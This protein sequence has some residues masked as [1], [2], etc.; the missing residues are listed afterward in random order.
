[1]GK[2]VPGGTVAFPYPAN[3]PKRLKAYPVTID[4]NDKRGKIERDNYASV[5]IP[6]RAS[7]PLWS[8][9]TNVSNG[10]GDDD[11]LTAVIP[12]DLFIANG[13]RID[14]MFAGSYASNA[15][16][17]Y[18]IFTLD[19]HT[20]YGAPENPSGGAWKALMTIFRSGTTTARVEIT[21]FTLLVGSESASAITDISTLDFTTPLALVCHGTSDANNDVALKASCGT[22][23]GAPTG[24]DYLTDESDGA[25]LTDEDTGEYLTE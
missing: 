15:N 4:Q 23:Y 14:A 2:G 18:P 19:G 25:F 22:F 1:M 3:V 9:C 8:H 5:T 24:A 17:K 11:L 16:E 20:I 12:E 13:D 6:A 21:L 7:L 10:G